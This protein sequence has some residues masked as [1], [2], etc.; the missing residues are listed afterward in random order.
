MPNTA[1][2]SNCMQHIPEKGTLGTTVVIKARYVSGAQFYREALRVY[3]GR[4]Q[5]FCLPLI[6]SLLAMPPEHLPL[7]P[8]KSFNKILTHIHT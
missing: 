5:L 4:Q 1:E 2:S 7:H 6:M 8:I 3:L